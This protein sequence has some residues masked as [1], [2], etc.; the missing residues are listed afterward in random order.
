MTVKQLSWSELPRA[1]LPRVSPGCPAGRR[2]R[3]RAGGAMP[4]PTPGVQGSGL[5]HSHL[6]D[7]AIAGCHRVG[8][9]E[10]R[11]HPR[12][13]D[14]AG[15]S[16]TWCHRR[17]QEAAQPEVISC[18]CLKRWGNVKYS[19]GFHLPET[20]A[21]LDGSPGAPGRPWLYLAFPS[22]GAVKHPNLP[23]SGSLQGAR[24]RALGCSPQVV[25]VFLGQTHNPGLNPLLYCA[26]LVQAHMCCCSVP[27]LLGTTSV[28]PRHL[29]LGTPP[30]AWPPHPANAH[31][32]PPGSCSHTQ[33][34][35]TRGWPCCPVPSVAMPR[36]RFT[37]ICN[38]C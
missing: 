31:P 2:Q 30:P 37:F 8:R 34:P 23:G 20:K 36:G 26:Q 22:P 21:W 9:G 13:W 32:A 35:G 25:P 5:G 17:Q 18:H 14:V 10:A 4:V 33:T 29:L 19:F 24:C 12:Q 6:W 1:A 28:P 38:S 11:C 15:S 16:V 27:G 3:P 7:I